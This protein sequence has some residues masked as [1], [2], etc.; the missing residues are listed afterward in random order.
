MNTEKM[1]SN[2]ESINKQSRKNLLSDNIYKF[3]LYG[4]TALIMII[5]V[6]S[7]V[8]VIASGISTSNE[9]GLSLGEL[10]FGDKYMP[11]KTDALAAGAIVFNTIWM[12]FLAILIAVPIAIG[13]A[14]MITRVLRG[15]S[16]SIMYSIVAI[17]AAIPSVIY[18]MFGYDVINSTL[19]NLGF[20]TGS[21]MSVII[22]VAFMIV[23]TIT[24]MTIS[25][26]KLTDRKMEESSYALGAT[27]TQTSFYITMKSAKAGII[28][29]I[30]FAVGRC[31]GETTA[32]SIIS[33]TSSFYDGIVLSPWNAS[34]F[35]GPAIMGMMPGGDYASSIYL[36]PILSSFL[37]VTS[38]LIFSCMK[39]TEFITN[40]TMKAKRQSSKVNIM[41]NV[42]KKYKEMG[43][44]S[45]TES[46]Q[47]LL[48][49]YDIANEI[50]KKQRT[51][52]I[53]DHA[54][55]ELRK[56]SINDNSRIESY[57]KV[58]TTQHNLFIYITALVGIVLL[59]SILLYLFSGGFELFN[60]DLLTSRDFYIVDNP[61]SG[62]EVYLWGLAVPM[63]G[64]ML[65]IIISLSIALP[66]G[67]A[68]GLFI[69]LYLRKD[70]KFGFFVTL[71]LQVLTSIPTI[72]WSTIA[73]LVFMGTSFDENYKGLEP[74][75]FLAIILLP[76]MIKT[77]ED[78]GNRV[79]RGMIEGTE[80]LGATK[81][82]T[83]TSIYLK[84]TFPSI[85]AAALL[86]CSIV[87]AESTIFVSL[88]SKGTPSHSGLDTWIQQ[89]GY[90]LS[91]TIWKLKVQVASVADYDVYVS[92]IKTIGIILMAIV[93]ALSM[94]SLLFTN[95]KAI[96]G[97]LLLM[98]VALF[99]TGCYEY[100]NSVALG[101]ALEVLAAMSIIGSIALA[102]IKRN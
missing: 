53:E 94:S 45:L 15:L 9:A 86:G 3:A 43:L 100:G 67:T 71:I 97:A 82:K 1:N 23:P 89:G 91:A 59:L 95:K 54:L 40:D 87:V 28:T 7:V 70:T 17:L 102:A 35:L 81:F 5:V 61:I 80:A 11:G 56:T 37:L 96:S 76:T 77:T 68:L 29:G 66:L 30:I 2:I 65:S 55:M 75:L 99:M 92:E 14:I 48:F 72:V 52:S 22:T 78:A 47:N 10:I 34:L 6:I 36:Y 79:N 64:T 88:M 26:I 19:I 8:L 38:M 60:W 57:K 41:N 46:E 50:S 58:K 90:T 101:I 85:M 31:L 83:T 4:V 44:A 27:K 63:M 49:N 18:G 13:T 32:I 42:N 12:A 51:F 62:D 25:S 93:F 84:E 33:P 69:S 20:V 21:L 39:Y 73:A 74:A 98:S 16:S 24:I